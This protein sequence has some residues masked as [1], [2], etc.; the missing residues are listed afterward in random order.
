MGAVTIVSIYLIF[1]FATAV[2]A[3][4]FIIAPA[5][6]EASIRVGEYDP[7]NY[8]PGLTRITLF[9]LSIIVAPLLIPVLLISSW[10]E[11][12]KVQLAATMAGEN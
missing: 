2:T 3:Y 10:S 4:L 8:S 9:G 1:C 6:E 12:F 7:I 5:L 11:A